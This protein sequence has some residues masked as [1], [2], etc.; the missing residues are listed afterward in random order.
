MKTLLLIAATLVLSVPPAAA[1]AETAS[2]TQAPIRTLPPVKIWPGGVRA[3]AGW[4]GYDHG[5][6]TETLSADGDTVTNVSDPTFQPFLPAPGRASGTAVIIAP[7]GG[8]RQLSI[9]KE[10]TELAQWLAA[11]GVAAFVLKYRIAP[12]TGEMRAFQKMLWGLPRGLPGKAAVVDGLEALRLIR[13]Q[14]KSYGI[15]VDRIGVI[16]F[17]AGGH[18]AGMMAVDPDASARPDFAGLI[19]GMPYEGELVALPAPFLP[20]GFAA[21]EAPL[22][23]PPRTPAPGRLPPLFMAMAQD[24]RAAE[25]GFRAFYD[26]LYD[27][28]YR[29]ELH[30]YQRGGHG[31]GMRPQGSTSD[32]FAD[33]F[34]DWMISEGLTSKP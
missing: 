2:A 4:P 12:I 28:G 3:V 22:T 31:F 10:G 23:A 15:R 13:A 20:Q 14:A 16:G 25:I 11:R 34:F 5:P 1:Q 8:F 7:G 27:A 6:V 18:V 17:S 19:Y 30:L 9:R 32:R 26:R 29:P 24:D 33:Q 21:L